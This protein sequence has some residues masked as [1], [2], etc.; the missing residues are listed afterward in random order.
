MLLIMYSSIIGIV[1]VLPFTSCAF[2]HA[3]VG[4]TLLQDGRASRE[5]SWISSA[6]PMVFVFRN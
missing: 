2:T 6:K 4:E 3:K 5:P 1:I